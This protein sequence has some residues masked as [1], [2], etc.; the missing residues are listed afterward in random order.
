MRVRAIG[1]FAEADERPQVAIVAGDLL[2]NHVPELELPQAGRVDDVPAGRK[3]KHS[4]GGRRVLSL[5]SFGAHFADAQVQARLDSIQKR[6][7]ADAAL[8]RNRALMPGQPPP[9][10]LD[11]E[12]GVGTHEQHVVAH[13][14]VDADQRLQVGPLDQVDLVDAHQRRDPGLLGGDEEA[15]DQ[16]RLEVRF[17]RAADHHELID[18]D[19]DDVLAAAAARLSTP[20]RGSTRSMIPSVSLATRNQTRS[21]AA[22]TCR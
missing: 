17:G 4:G 21:P 18:V 6:R 8:A 2:G 10:A 7:L 13:L 22:T 19:D 15:V 12:T 20:T 11:A 9:Q 14:A 16:V 5:L 1:K 3:R